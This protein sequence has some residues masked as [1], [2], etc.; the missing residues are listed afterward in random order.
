MARQNT[1]QIT[2]SNVKQDITLVAIY[3][4]EVVML[5]LIHEVIIR[6]LEAV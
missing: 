5:I 1:L 4:C 6:N 2:L 3:G